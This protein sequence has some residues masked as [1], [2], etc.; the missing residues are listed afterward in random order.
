MENETPIKVALVRGD[1]LN[2]WEGKLWEKLG[3]DFAV[4]GFCSQNNAYSTKNLAFPVVQLPTTTD[5]FLINQYAKLLKGQFQK[6]RGLEKKLQTFSI[7]HTAEVYFYYT[8][9]AVQAKKKNPALKVVATVWDNSFG[10]FEY[11]YWPGHKVAPRFWREKMK[12]IITETI[13]GVDLFLPVS[14]TSK[15]LLLDYGVPA[16]KI[17]VLEPAISTTTD[18]KKSVPKEWVGK[19]LFL[20]VNRLVKEKGVYDVLYGWKMYLQ[21]TNPHNKVLLIIGRGPEEQNIRRLIKE[22]G[23]EVN[24]QV[25]GVMDNA[26]VRVLYPAAKALVLG[27]LPTSTWQEQFG[28]V[29]GEAIMSGCPIIATSTGSIPGV[30][31]NAGLI[32]PPGNP[33]ALAEALKHLED[34][35]VREKLV[36]ATGKVSRKFSDEQFVAKLKEIYTRLVA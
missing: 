27:S 4:T 36:A 24:T 31:E 15:A 21:Q 1:S 17:Q 20:M 23:I 16:E 12:R 33:I 2:V 14:E 10:R 5:S 35:D 8:F 18:A 6:M 7:A 30:V 9:Q 19:E 32:V 26:Q 28:Y 22:W 34:K 13:Q 25:V 29:L 3:A 11:N